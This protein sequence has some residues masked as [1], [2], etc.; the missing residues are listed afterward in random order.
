MKNV[1][2]IGKK[3][4]GKSSLI[5]SLIGKE[6]FEVGNGINPCTLK[7]TWFTVNGVTIRE[8][9]GLDSFDDELNEKTFNQ[10]IEMLTYKT[11]GGV[12]W[13]VDSLVVV[14]DVS[15]DNW[16]FL[17]F[18]TDCIFYR[19]YRDGYKSNIVLVL[20]K[21][22]KLVNDKG[23]Q[24]DIETKRNEQERIYEE[25]F[26]K[27]CVDVTCLACCTKGNKRSISGSYNIDK[28]SEEII[29]KS[30]VKKCVKVWR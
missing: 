25:Y 6:A 20:N 2:I 13:E 22:D 29:R 30:E 19:C 11:Y 21:L 15:C 23:N 4:T 18:I 1:L 17:D 12:K 26:R 5:N 7:E 8:L 27:K 14:V 10:T 9:P 28:I 24:K 16:E 3:G